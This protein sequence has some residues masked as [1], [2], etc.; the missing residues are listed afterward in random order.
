[1]HQDAKLS[2]TLAKIASLK[3]DLALL[4][5]K[6]GSEQDTIQISLGGHKEPRL[7]AS[8]AQ[9]EARREWRANG[10]RPIAL[11]ANFSESVTR[12]C[13]E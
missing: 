13:A 3:S 7:A 4:K 8:G 1:M 12:S 5:L 2:L 9:P 6:L 10:T 11:C